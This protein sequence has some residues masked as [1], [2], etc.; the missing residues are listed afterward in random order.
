MRSLFFFSQKA[1]LLSG[2]APYAV[3]LSTP[4]VVNHRAESAFS[5]LF[6]DPPGVLSSAALVHAFHASGVVR[7]PAEVADMIAFE[8]VKAHLAALPTVPVS[9]LSV[10]P[11][12]SGGGQ[13]DLPAANDDD[14]DADDDD[15]DDDAKGSVKAAAG[16]ADASTEPS[17][18][19]QR[20][21][22]SDAPNGLFIFY[23]ILFVFYLYFLFIFI[24]NF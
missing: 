7:S 23:F 18:K 16:A 17:G 2:A 12:S 19:Q 9:M 4:F 8:R 3:V 6:K 5:V 13:P 10:L 20:L 21:A 22:T 24:F 11:T 14:A 1:T 15:A